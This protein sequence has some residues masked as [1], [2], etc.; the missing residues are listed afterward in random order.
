M[1]DGIQEPVN[2]MVPAPRGQLH[3]TDYPGTAPPLVLM[4]G[5]PDDSRI[6]DR[7]ASQ[8]APR[9]VVAVDWL[10]YGRS[11]RADP[12]FPDAGSHQ[13]EL[14]AVLDSL[15]LRRVTLVG[16]D[17][18]GPD[19]IDF[20]ASEPGRVG[21]LVL[22]N[23]YYGHAPELRL[24]EMIRLLADPALTPLADAMIGEPGQR[25]WLLVH[26]GRQWAMDPDDQGGVAFA[27][28]V[29]QFFGDD[30]QPDALAAIRAWTAGLFP[31]LERQDARITA[32][33]LAGLDLPVTLVFGAADQYLSP[34]LARH[35]AGLFRHADVHLV[36]DASHWP[37]WDQPSEVAKLIMH[38]APTDTE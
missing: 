30:T 1:S 18:S 9:R 25:L 16:H 20:A 23:T 21:R 11:D 14:R 5:F 7:L 6:Y 33:A 29:P 12:G 3:V 37:Q 8:L 31:A 24:P 32:G 13:G 4:H 19:A 35:L 26:T 2:R 10:G 15:D 34:D 17:A 38:A 22:L 36:H 28:I 27:S